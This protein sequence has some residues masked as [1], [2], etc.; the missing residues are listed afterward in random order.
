MRARRTGPR[1][2]RLGKSLR[3][4]P[5]YRAPNP[6]LTRLPGADRSALPAQAHYLSQFAKNPSPTLKLAPPTGASSSGPEIVGAVFIDPSAQ[7]DPSAKIG[8][9]VSIGKNV[10][11][12]KG[13]RVADSIVLEGTVLEVCL[14]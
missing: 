7:V 10:V 11:V 8:P 1:S 5:I 3:H 9:N 14:Y 13:V 12:G 4:D 2:S 6:L